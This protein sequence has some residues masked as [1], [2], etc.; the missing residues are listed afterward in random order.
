MKNKKIIFLSRS[1]NAGGAERQLTQLANGLKCEGYKPLVAVFYSGG[2]LENELAAAGV[3]VVSLGKKGRWDLI[4][5]LFRLWR[6]LRRE[7]PAIIHSYLVVPNI[8]MVLM[9]P[10]IPGTK[11]VWGVRASFMDLGRY[12]WTAR[13]TFRMSCV[14]ARFAD[15]I[16]VNSNSGRDYHAALGYPVK[17]MAVV[18]NGFDCSSFQPDA[19]KRAEQRRAWN[20]DSDVILVGMVARLDP[21]KD[22]FTFIE[23]AREV[24][25]TQNRVRFVCIGDGPQSIKSELQ[26]YARRVGVEDAMLWTG[27]LKEMPS[28]YNA[29]DI[30]VSSS[31]GEG[32]PN[33]IGEA[34]CCGV[35]CVA[36]RVGDSADI[37][38]DT[39]I[40][41][42]VQDS[43]ALADGLLHMMQILQGDPNKS[44]SACRQR[45]I[46]LYDRD[47]LIS[48]TIQILEGIH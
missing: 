36:T 6:Y 7:K 32:F 3:P 48:R 26:S 16:I 23:A 15:K 25:L 4:G 35:P 33:A 22:H 42:P 28:V 47:L 1:L 20:I 29:L 19:A 10:F 5:F 45:I 12:D 27:T 11:F 18:P 34:M 24:L 44:H 39:G 21:M 13:F 40:V 14:L 8:I 17:K 43:H 9:K 31:R 46:E 37:I 38:G 2:M 41:V 30:H